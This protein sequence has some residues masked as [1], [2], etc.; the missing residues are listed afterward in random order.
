MNVI[1]FLIFEN[2]NGIYVE[3][4]TFYYLELFT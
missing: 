4:G 3:L 2:V 1:M